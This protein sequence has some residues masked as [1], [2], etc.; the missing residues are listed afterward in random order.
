MKRDVNAT[1]MVL[2]LV[3]VFS[4]MVLIVYNAYAYHNLGNRYKDARKEIE[5]AYVRLNVTQQE[6]AAK[7]KELAVR[8]AALSEK[9][10]QLDKYFKD[11]NLSKS[12]ESSLSEMFSDIRDENAQL[13]GDVKTLETQV[14]EKSRELSDI[15][16]SYNAKIVQYTEVVG[17]CNSMDVGI[18]DIKNNIDRIN[19]QL[20][21]MKRNL[22]SLEDQGNSTV[23]SDAKSANN[24]RADIADKVASIDNLVAAM[25]N[26]AD[27][28]R[29]ARG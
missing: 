4:V 10:A 24:K 18:L 8:E 20:E 2:L 3:A 28:F 7:D 19:T 21:G 25:E 23:L 9:E 26:W 22:D 17:Y 14:D 12:R 15:T 27:K 29:R 13:E 11:L 16:R 5:V 1:L 6:L